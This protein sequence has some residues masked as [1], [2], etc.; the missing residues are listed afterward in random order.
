MM[1]MYTVYLHVIYLVYV[2]YDGY[3]YCIFT[4]TITLEDDG[5]VQYTLHVVYKVYEKD[6]IYSTLYSVHVLYLVYVE[7]DGYVQ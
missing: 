2:E 7:Y 6:D 5:Y 3:V 1:G 4:C